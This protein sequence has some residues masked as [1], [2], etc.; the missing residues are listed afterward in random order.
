M[1]SKIKNISQLKKIA[2]KL[3]SEKKRIVLC[4]GVFDLIH[5]G[6]IQYF[7][8]AK[9]YGEVLVV[10]V[11]DDR[12]IKKIDV[13]RRPLIFPEIIRLKWLAELEVVDFVTICG[14]IGPWKVMK[15]IQPDVYVKGDD[16][17][18]RLKNPKSGLNKDKR[19]IESL[20]GKLKFV[21]CFT[22]AS[23]I[24]RAAINGTTL[25]F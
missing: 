25:K 8:D 24:L 15:A 10:S 2:I 14:D 23:E 13:K 19:I 20:G 9:K 16:A 5:W 21:R 1:K 12:Y 6:H 18:P 3:H 4:H 17:K 7:Q 22:H 11:V